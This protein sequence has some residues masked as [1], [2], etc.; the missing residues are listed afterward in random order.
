MY[1][2]PLKHFKTN[3]ITYFMHSLSNSLHLDFFIF[4]CTKYYWWLLKITI[5]IRTYLVTSNGELLIV[6][7]IGWSNQFLR[8]RLIS[9]SNNLIAHKFVQ[10]G[11]FFFNYSLATSMTNWA[12]HFAFLLCYACLGITPREKT[13]LWQLPNMSKAFKD[14]GHYW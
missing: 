6:L 8:K 3:Y 2:F 14:T 13:G 12:N 11:C 9:H 10:Q 4:C 5:S 1:T 7:H